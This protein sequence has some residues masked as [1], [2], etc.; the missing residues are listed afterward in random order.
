M[1]RTHL[2]SIITLVLLSFANLGLAAS[3]SKGDDH[4]ELKPCTAYNSANGAFYDLNKI[5]VHPLENHKKAHKDDR[6]ESWHVRGWDYGTNFTM[7]F[8]SPVI[9]T[10]KDVEGIKE[11]AVKSISAF[12][13]KGDR[14][15]SIGWVIHRLW[16]LDGDSQANIW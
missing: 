2:S 7:N 5:R 4:K 9:E 10:L 3:T 6:E 8:C 12:Y 1:R 13:R 16:M 14:T 15:Y 11:D